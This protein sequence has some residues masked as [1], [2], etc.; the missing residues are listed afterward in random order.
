P[1][2]CLTTYNSYGSRDTYKIGNGNC[3]PECNTAACNYDGGDC[4][5]CNE[6]FAVDSTGAFTY[7]CAPS[8]E[9][10]ESYRNDVLPK[11]GTIA[12]GSQNVQ[13]ALPWYLLREVSESG[14][15]FSYRVYTCFDS[16]ESNCEYNTTK[17][18]ITSGTHYRYYYNDDGPLYKYQWD[19]PWTLTEIDGLSRTWPTGSAASTSSIRL[20][21]NNGNT[22]TYGSS[23]VRGRVEVHHSMNGWGT[24]CRDSFYTSEAQVV[25]RQ[26]GLPFASASY[27]NTYDSWVAAGSNT[28]SIWLDD[29]QCTGSESTLNSCPHNGWG[30]VDCGHSRDVGVQCD[31]STSG[32]NS[33]TMRVCLAAY[34]SYSYSSSDFICSEQF[35]V[36]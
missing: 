21:D 3:D 31:S 9:F 22:A 24:V 14:S 5:E 27:G 34:G 36:Q 11:T 26:L 35:T 4:L 16:A 8:R 23:Y 6:D 12:L 15:S 13:I 7:G 32:I 18:T 2:T 29:L 17:S 20:V 33:I 19:V 25:C 30:N 1:E 10:V 28:Q